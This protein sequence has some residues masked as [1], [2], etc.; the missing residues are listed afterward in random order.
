LLSLGAVISLTLG[1]VMLFDSTETAMRVS[2]SV[3][4]P[5]VAAV[6]AFFIVVLGLVVKAWMKKPRTGQQG[7][8]GEIGVAISD[9][10]PFGKVAVHGEY[11]NARSETRI[12]KGEKVVVTKAQNLEINVSRYTG[13]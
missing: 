11:W 12:P 2:W 13:Q 10:D 3:I 4:I 1:S 8:L 7:L 9:I 6:S 5:T